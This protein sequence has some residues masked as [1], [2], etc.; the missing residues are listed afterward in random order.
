MIRQTI[1]RLLRPLRLE[2]VRHPAQVIPAPLPDE[3]QY[4]RPE[5][6]CR[7]YRPWLGTTVS[8]RLTPAIR[9]NT[10]LSPQKLYTL[11]QCVRLTRN[12]PGDF[13]EAGTGSGGAARLMLD[14][15]R[16]L[17]L[18][19]RGWFLDTFEGYQKVDSHRD[20]SHVAV[21]QCRLAPRDQVTELLQD[22]SAEVHIIAGLIP[23]TLAEVH[24]EH[25][26]FAHIDVNLH[27][28]TLAATRFCLERLSP[29]GAMVFDD[30]NWPACY[31]AR[32]AIDEACE[33]FGQELIALP[34]STQAIL[35]KR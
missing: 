29:G 26:A 4:A 19:R 5:D 33:Q 6:F 22:K 35:F 24:T 20:G 17:G 7:L 25:I 14:T 34:E 15:A 1:N 31:S 30:Y 18:S 13:F 16:E 28:P 3:A 23:A 21:N 32:K 10:M 9:E 11:L 2:L 27:E 8:R 12:V